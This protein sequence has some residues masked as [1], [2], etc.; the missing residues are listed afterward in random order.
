MSSKHH[1]IQGFG[2][3]AMG[4][5]N[6]AV[7]APMWLSVWTLAMGG[8]TVLFGASRWMKGE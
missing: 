6:F 3:V 7:H 8:L 2:L 1:L 5:G 4:V